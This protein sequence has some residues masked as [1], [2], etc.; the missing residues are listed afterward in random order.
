LIW[1]IFRY[2]IIYEI[3]RLLCFLGM[4]LFFLGMRL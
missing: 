3:M 2:E 1:E 4:R